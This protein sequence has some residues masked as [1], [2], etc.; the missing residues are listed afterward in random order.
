METP[1]SK[2]KTYRIE[3]IKW[4]DIQSTVN[5]PPNDEWECPIA[6][7]VGILIDEFDFNG[8]KICRYLSTSNDELSDY[9]DIPKGCI[10]SRKEIGDIDKKDS[11]E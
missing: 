1:K 6:T 3:L 5:G 10:Y 7:T 9:I 11:D 8:I 2:N 4:V